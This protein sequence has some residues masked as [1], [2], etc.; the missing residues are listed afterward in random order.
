MLCN[1]RLRTFSVLLC[2]YVCLQDPHKTK[3]KKKM[4]ALSIDT[5]GV[6]FFLL[7]QQLHLPNTSSRVLGETGLFPLFQKQTDR[8]DT[9]LTAQCILYTLTLPSATLLHLPKLITPL[10]SN[11]IVLQRWMEGDRWVAADLCEVMTD[12]HEPELSAWGRCCCFTVMGSL[13]KWQSN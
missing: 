5:P 12:S 13:L 9:T 2:C 7:M 3:K 1:V 6:S 11:I 4:S 8:S 10:L